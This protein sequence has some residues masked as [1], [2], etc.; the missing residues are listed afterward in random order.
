MEKETGYLH[1]KGFFNE[2]NASS[3]DNIVKFTTFGQDHVWKKKILK[4]IPKKGFVLD[5]ACGT[6]ILTSLLQDKGHVT[7]GI[8]LTYGYLKILKTKRRGLFCVNGIAEVLP[9]KNNYFDYVVSSYL[10]K[11]AN[12]IHLVDECF[13]VLKGGGKVVFHD[14]IFPNRVVFRKLWKFYFKILKRAGRYIKSWN[15]VF[16]KL[17]SFIMNSGWYSNL[18]E[19]LF[20]KGFTNITS[21]SITFETAAVISAKKP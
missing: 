13:R 16:N 9:F 6:G 8:D 4:M 10:P 3:Y 1:A 18:P 2:F 11:Y 19:I 5:L 20:N 14:F 7:F 12:L 17:D 21:E 15:N